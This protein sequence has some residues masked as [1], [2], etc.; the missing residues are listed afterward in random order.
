[1]VASSLV[2]CADGVSAWLVLRS[3][4]QA[5]FGLLLWG[6]AAVVFVLGALLPLLFSLLGARFSKVVRWV[7]LTAC[8]AVALPIGL[9]SMHDYPHIGRCIG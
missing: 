8:I 5:I 2:I 7:F 9:F 1:M 6:V 3:D 4:C